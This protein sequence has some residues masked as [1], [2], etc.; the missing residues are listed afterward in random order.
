MNR[1][2]ITIMISETYQKVI[3]YYQKLLDLLANKIEGEPIE[4][5]PELASYIYALTIRKY[6]KVH[7]LL[8]Y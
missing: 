2:Q 6:E 8:L 7:E 1:E 5:V 3:D 4:E